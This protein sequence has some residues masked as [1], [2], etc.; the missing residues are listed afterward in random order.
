VVSAPTEERG[1]LGPWVC[2]PSAPPAPLALAS[3][4]VPPKDADFHPVEEDAYLYA[5]FTTTN[6]TIRSRPLVRL[7]SRGP[8]FLPSFPLFGYPWNVPLTPLTSPSPAL[9]S[10][11]APGALIPVTV[12]LSPLWL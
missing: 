1:D 2:R 4:R 7:L 8:P 3:Q 9:A 11:G 12:L 6:R 10:T 5:A